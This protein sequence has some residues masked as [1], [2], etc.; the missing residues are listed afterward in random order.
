MREGGGG[1]G[2]ERER[3]RE[4]IDSCCELLPFTKMTRVCDGQPKT[5]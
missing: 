4:R 5:P 1:G 2:R 3:E